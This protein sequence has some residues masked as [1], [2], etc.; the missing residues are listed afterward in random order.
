M[1]PAVSAKGLTVSYGADEVLRDV[2][3]SV[4]LG[5]CHALFGRNGS[6]K[7]TLLKTVLGLLRPKCG[8]VRVFGLDPIKEEVQVKARIAYVADG[9]GFYPWMTVKEA[10]ELQASLRPGWVKEI[11]ASLLARFDLDPAASAVALS[12]GQK[13]QLALTAAIASDPEVL[14]LDEPTSG[15]DPLVRRQFLEAIV[16]AFQERNPERKTIFVATHLIQEFEGVVDEFSVLA[17]GRIALS[18][19]ADEARRRFGR[20]R[21]WFEN[22]IPATLPVKALG[23]P[24]RLGRSVEVLID[25]QLEL[26][27]AGRALTQVG[28]TRLETS[29]LSLEDIFMA[30]CAT[31]NVR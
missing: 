7:T 3:F 8:T 12:K 16:G 31:G 2:A 6:G 25:G 4:D 5:R 10:L 14:I 23:T 18:L 27:E 9:A 21:A 17:H 13:T 1:N 30:T 26:E 28:A 29:A 15:L 24:K 22:D 19:G 20:V 11:E